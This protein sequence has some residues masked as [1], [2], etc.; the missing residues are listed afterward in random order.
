MR[1]DSQNVD[2]FAQ[3]DQS[4]VINN[5][6]RRLK[7][8]KSMY[9][10]FHLVINLV[11]LVAFRANIVIDFLSVVPDLH[12]RNERQRTEGGRQDHRLCDLLAGRL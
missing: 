3:Y 12:R 10:I 4:K 5:L 2:F 6:E 1:S 11:L 9:Y 8:E 7:Y